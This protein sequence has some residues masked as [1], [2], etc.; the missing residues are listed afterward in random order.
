MQI[1]KILQGH[2]Y[3]VYNRGNNGQNIFIEDLNYTYF[4]DL[5]KKHLTTN[6]KVFSYCLLPNHFHLL[7]KINEA[8]VTPSQ[9]LSNLFN[10]Y[11]KAIN[12]KYNRTGSLLEKPFKRIRIS[13][14]KYLK[15]L[16]LYI[17]LNPENHQVYKDFTNYKYSSYKSIMSEGKTNIQR[18]EV[19][20]WFDDIS[21]FKEIHQHRKI[22]LNLKNKKLFL[23]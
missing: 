2:Y 16:V 1:E 5:I 18:K 20:S 4:L 11:T 17:H 6:F 23:E 19:I 9:K 13:N 3:H 14:E 12:K 22:H 8:C 10:A 15:T 7:L 21:N